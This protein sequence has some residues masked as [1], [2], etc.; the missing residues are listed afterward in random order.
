MK[1]IRDRGAESEAVPYQDYLRIDREQ[2]GKMY[3]VSFER[4]ELNREQ[5]I[6]IY[7][8]ILKSLWTLEEED[9]S[10]GRI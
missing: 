2:E 4:N 6:R 1:T 9:I 8:A 10:E 3:S 5:A 7:R